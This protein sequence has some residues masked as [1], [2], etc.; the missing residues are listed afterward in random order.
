M[1]VSGNDILQSGSFRL[2]SGTSQ[3][4]CIGIDQSSDETA[5]LIDELPFVEQVAVNKSLT[6]KILTFTIAFESRIPQS[7][8]TA[9]AF[10][11]R[12]SGR[13]LFH[14]ELLSHKLEILQ[15]GVP[16]IDPV[17]V[18][19]QLTAGDYVSGFFYVS[20]GSR[21]EFTK[22]V[23]TTDEKVV[24]FKITPGSD[25]G[26]YG[27][28]DVGTSDVT[29]AS[30]YNGTTGFVSIFT[31]K[32]AIIQSQASADT[33]KAALE[34]LPEVDSVT[35]SRYGPNEASGYSWVITIST[36]LHEYHCPE[37]CLQV[38]TTKIVSFISPTTNA[39]FVLSSYRNG[40]PE[41]LSLK[42]SIIPSMTFH[43]LWFRLTRL[44]PRQM[45]G[46]V[47]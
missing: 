11:F 31:R 23:S 45:D 21:A 25:H 46:W 29:L 7:G 8:N 32:K 19:V 47:V 41:F 13:E 15:Q 27:V 34:A 17:V 10:D 5:R 37:W 20:M 18:S 14:P 42:E 6:N 30:H 38:Q 2:G 24:L 33:F 35:V 36:S 39:D 22:I 28:T 12:T 9:R 40:R 4:T 1:L 3:T 16:N 43:W 44:G 26:Y